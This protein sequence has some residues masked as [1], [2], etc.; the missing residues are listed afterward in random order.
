MRY[1][2]RVHLVVKSSYNNF[3]ACNSIKSN[4][5]D[6]DKSLNFITRSISLKYIVMYI[7]HSY[8]K[9]N[10]SSSVAFY[11]LKKELNTLFFCYRGPNKY[12]LCCR[13]WERVLQTN[14]KWKSFFKC[15]Q[16]KPLS[17]FCFILI[18]LL[19]P[20][21]CFTRCDGY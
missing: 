5:Y 11:D 4:K 16:K 18:I 7:I 17:R 2:L 8:I 12:F 15:L 19:R 1:F 3:I 21:K 14:F 9:K 13:N 6:C 10:C 20:T